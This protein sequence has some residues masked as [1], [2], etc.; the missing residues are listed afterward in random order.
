[1]LLFL[2]SGVSDMMS[3]EM[4]AQNNKQGETSEC[5]A[6]GK[7]SPPRQDRWMEQSFYQLLGL[8]QTTHLGTTH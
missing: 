4:P 5:S 7:H 6:L 3:I 1:M 8:T 2:Q